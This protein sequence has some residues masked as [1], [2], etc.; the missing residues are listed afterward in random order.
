[1]DSQDQTE[2][3]AVKRVDSTSKVLNSFINE[4]KERCSY[5]R[6]LNLIVHNVLESSADNGSKGKSHNIS[7]VTAKFLGVKV[8]I[9][10]AN[11]IGQKKDNQPRPRYLLSLNV[12]KL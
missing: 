8:K 5:K 7:T 9:T 11:R 4:E 6:R 10:N 2:I 3:S 1:M 12:R